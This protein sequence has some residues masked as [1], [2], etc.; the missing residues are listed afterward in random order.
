MLFKMLEF[1]G[2]FTKN[3]FELLRLPCIIGLIK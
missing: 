3:K 2:H 1:R